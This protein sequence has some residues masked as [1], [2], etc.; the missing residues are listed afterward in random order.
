MN[1][2]RGNLKGGIKWTEN[3]T[4]SVLLAFSFSKLALQ[5]EFTQEPNLDTASAELL[6]T[7]IS[8]AWAEEPMSRPRRESLWWVALRDLRRE[9]ITNMK[10]VGDRMEPCFTP[11]HTGKLCDT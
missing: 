4:A 8:S 1:G 2:I 3:E 10:I 6:M 9:S 7:R 11:R 5:K